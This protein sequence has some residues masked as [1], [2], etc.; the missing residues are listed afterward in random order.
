MDSASNAVNNTFIAKFQAV[1]VPT[2]INTITKANLPFICYPN[3]SDGSF[4]VDMSGFGTGLKS[5]YI[6]DNMGRQIYAKQTAENKTLVDLNLSIGLYFVRVCQADKTATDKII[7][8]GM[9]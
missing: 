5:L 4:T 2:G 3:P 1:N 7:I 8:T 6:Y 9:Q